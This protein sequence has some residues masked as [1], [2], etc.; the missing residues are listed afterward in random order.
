MQLAEELRYLILAA[1][2]EGN[3]MITE[4]LSPLGL[5]PSQAE[6]L[7]VLQDHQ[8]LS[9]I[10][11]GKLLICETGSPSRL[12]NG[13]VEADLVKRVPSTANGRMVVLTLTEQGQEMAASVRTKEAAFYESMSTVFDQLPPEDIM[14]LLWRFVEGRPAGEAL[15]RR[16][17]TIHEAEKPWTVPEN[18]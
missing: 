15:T 7:R 12:I 3:R 2:R 4:A 11:L 14:A 1:Q 18:E 6:A 16:K 8:P 13:L 9:L 10:A 5:T 17:H